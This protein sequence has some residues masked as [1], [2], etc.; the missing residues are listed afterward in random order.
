M[1]VTIKTVGTQIVTLTP[2]NKEFVARAKQLGAKWNPA[3][4]A[5]TFDAR[6][7]QAVRELCIELFGTD[8]SVPAN[9]V[10]LRI[11]ASDYLFNGVV[12]FGGRDVARRESRDSYPRMQHGVVVVEGEFN[13]RGGSTKHPEITREEAQGVVLEIRDIPADA[14]ARYI[15][16]DLKRRTDRVNWL[17]SDSRL[18]ACIDQLNAAC[19]RGETED[20]LEALREAVDKAKVAYDER[21]AN[22]TTLA[23]VPAA[24]WY[25]TDDAE[26]KPNADL[27][28]A[29]TS[30]KAAIEAAKAVGMSMDA[31]LKMVS[32]S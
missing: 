23:D 15:A 5:W 9:A 6:D 24:V 22:P 11:N 13:Y 29:A 17:N 32:E 31:I 12:E 4:K 8:G 26:A 20:R 16:D 25:A 19:S 30:L 3:D 21:Q 2:Y 14:A 10:D 27:E 1:N 18:Q 28:A 7:E